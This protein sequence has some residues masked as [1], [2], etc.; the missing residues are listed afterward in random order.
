MERLTYAYNCLGRFGEF[1]VSGTEQLRDEVDYLRKAILS[2]SSEI[3][4]SKQCLHDARQQFPQKLLRV[5][6][7]LADLNSVFS[8]LLR[9]LTFRV[10]FPN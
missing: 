8:I 4:E 6:I 3:L 2:C 1:D 5:I 10:S 7:I 9:H